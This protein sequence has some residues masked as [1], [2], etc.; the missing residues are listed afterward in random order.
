MPFYKNIWFWIDLFL[1]ILC[2]AFYLLAN[3]ILWKSGVSRT[4]NLGYTL[5]SLLCLVAKL[6][7][8]KCKLRD[9]VLELKLGVGSDR[10][11]NLSFSYLLF[12]LG[13]TQQIAPVP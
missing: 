5:L 1:I 12:R 10:H 11:W 9:P 7:I 6:P 3:P 8:D 4:P 2:A 13:F